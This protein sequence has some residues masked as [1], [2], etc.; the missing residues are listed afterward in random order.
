M[1]NTTFMENLTNPLTY[2]QGI[3]DASNGWFAGVF[4]AT[5]FLLIFMIFSDYDPKNVFLAD[6]FLTA[7]LAALF[8]GAGMLEGWALSIPIVLLVTAL[9]MKVWGDSK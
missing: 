8:F 2:V 6:S 5:V 7:I 3:N 9:V 1:Y 4:L